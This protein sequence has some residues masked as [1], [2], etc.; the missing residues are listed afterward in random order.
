[1]ATRWVDATTY[2]SRYVTIDGGVRGHVKNLKR[3][4]LEGTADWEIITTP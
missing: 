3:N 4:L 2:P 1:V